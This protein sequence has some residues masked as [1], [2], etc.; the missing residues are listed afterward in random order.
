MITCPNCQRA[1]DDEYKYCLGCGTPL[2]K[3]EVKPAAEMVDC[4]HCGASVPSQFKFCGNC[5]GA[6]HEPPGAG[7]GVSGWS[8]SESTMEHARPSATP[9]PG[10]PE[11]VQKSAD[12]TDPL[13]ASSLGQL[14]IIKPDGTEGGKITVVE[15]ETVLGRVSESETL[16]NDPF[17]SPEHAFLV[18][19]DGRYVIRDNKSLNGVYIRIQGE[20]EL[21]D[22]DYIRIGQELMEFRLMAQVETRA[23]SDETLTHGSPDAGYWG[24]LSLLGGP[25]SETRAFVFSTDEIIIGREIG[26]ILFREDGFVSKKHAKI[27]KFD[28]RVM[29]RDLD[30]SNGTY[31]RIRGERE[32]G[33]GDLVLMGQQLFRLVH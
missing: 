1:N 11:P 14:V 33:S 16:Q 6:V 27:N 22:G 26:D 9:T 17:L 19:R 8:G 29:L 21:Q 23:S 24:R 15:G 28:G 25:D 13:G 18:A 20:A 12:G 7:S 3:P 10:T 30:S 2:P 5:G 31:V 32:I 4:P